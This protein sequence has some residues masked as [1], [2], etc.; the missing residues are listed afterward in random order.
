MAHL[1]T[2]SSTALRGG[3]ITGAEQDFSKADASNHALRLSDEAAPVEIEFV[4]V[5]TFSVFFSILP[6]MKEPRPGATAIAAGPFSW[7]RESGVVAQGFSAYSK[8]VVRRIISAIGPQLFR[9]CSLNV[10]N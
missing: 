10:S 1:S 3:R 4:A 9:D 6:G 8:G 7:S 5:I 2:E